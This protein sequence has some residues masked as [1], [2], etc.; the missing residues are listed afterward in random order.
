MRGIAFPEG[1]TTNLLDPCCGCGLALRRIATGN[2]CWTYGVE[3]DEDRAAE[4]QD[5]LH[6]VAVGSFFNSRIS[7]EAWPAIYPVAACSSVRRA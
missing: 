2:N 1:V 5:R 7:H 3:M 6:R 4:S